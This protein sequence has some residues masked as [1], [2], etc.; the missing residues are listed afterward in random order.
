MNHNDFYGF[1]MI[2][3]IVMGA[4][5][6]YVKC[7]WVVWTCACGFISSLMFYLFLTK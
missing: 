6:V 3:N 4:L 2:L 5:N 7:W 1:A